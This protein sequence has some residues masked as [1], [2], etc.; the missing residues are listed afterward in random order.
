[1]FLFDEERFETQ[2]TSYREK[3]SDRRRR[4][5]LTHEGMS[6]GKVT[7]AA[8]TAAGALAATQNRYGGNGVSESASNKARASSERAGGA[9]RGE[10]GVDW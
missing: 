4:M 7:C 1:M 6:L 10:G 8:E 9:I 5:W 3:L 2:P